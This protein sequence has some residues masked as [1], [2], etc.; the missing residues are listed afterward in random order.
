MSMKI[1]DALIRDDDIYCD[2]KE[3]CLLFVSHRHSLSPG[4]LVQY[5]KL[6]QCFEEV[7]PLTKLIAGTN[8]E[9]VCNLL[10]RMGDVY[11]KLH[12][13]DNA[14]VSFHGCVCSTY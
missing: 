9:D 14:I 11:K 10:I 4:I 5:Q 7:L 3:G 13:W 2:E 8:H 1:L 12:D 6:I